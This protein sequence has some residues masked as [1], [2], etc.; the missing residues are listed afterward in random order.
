MASNSANFNPPD[1]RVWGSAGILFPAAIEAKNNSRW[2]KDALLLIWSVLPEIAMN[3]AE[4]DFCKRLEEC[5]PL[6]DTL[7]IECDMSYSRY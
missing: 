7:N 6:L 2:F 4:Q 3:D 5:Q 1:Y